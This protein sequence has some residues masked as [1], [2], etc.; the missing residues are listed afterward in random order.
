LAG[1]RDLSGH[2]HGVHRDYLDGATLSD[3]ANTPRLGA[4]G[5]TRFR[6]PIYE[7][8][9]D[10]LLHLL[11]RAEL[12]PHEVTASVI[13]EQYLAW[14][15]LLD[16]LNLDVAGEY[17]VMAATLLLIKSFAMLPHPELADTE[18]AE[19]LKRDLVERLLEYQRYREAAEKLSERAILGRDVFTTPGESAPE[20]ANAKQYTVS[21]FDLVE[22]IGAVLK[23]VADKTPRKIE[24]RDIPVA[25][26]IPRIMRAL[27]GAARIPFTALFEDANDRSLVIATFMALLELI[28]RRDVRAFQEVRFGEILLERVAAVA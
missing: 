26:C 19:E 14:L 3:E 23:R 2:E 25:E 11:K 18:E 8:P 4:D 22:A 12:D 15:E 13:T 6:L 9:L 5:G 10:L 28:R 20:D 21:I 7:G 27:E 17:L 1:C 24:L 16:Q